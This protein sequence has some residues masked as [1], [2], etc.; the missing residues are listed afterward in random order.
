[1]III[2]FIDMQS[3]E[4]RNRVLESLQD[5]LSRDPVKTNV[6]GFTQL[7]LVE[8]TRK[9]TRESLEHILCCE[10]PTCQGR[11]RVKTVETVCYEIMREIIRV[12]HL[13]SSEQF[14]VYASHAVAEYLINEESHGLLAELE[15]FIGKQIQV[16]TEPFYTQEQFDVVVM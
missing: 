8:M 1:M 9:R 6:N 3:E 16:K 11:G 14:V 7:G 12:H 4:H 15:V 5:A 2:D 10:C 13:F